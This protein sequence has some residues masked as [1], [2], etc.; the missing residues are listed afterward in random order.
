[1]N[2]TLVLLLLLAPWYSAGAEDA[3]QSLDSPLGTG[4]GLTFSTSSTKTALSLGL[5]Q[6]LVLPQRTEDGKSWRKVHTG[7]RWEGALE[8]AVQESTSAAL[9][10]FASGDVFAP[11]LRLKLGLAY[12]SA[13][14]RDDTE[15]VEAC[16]TF[17]NDLEKLRNTEREKR[18]MAEV[19]RLAQRFEI[20]GPT[21]EKCAEALGEVAGRI[22]RA[23]LRASVQRELDVLLD[24]H[25]DPMKDVSAATA[26]ALEKVGKD[27]SEPG[28]P[29]KKEKK[30]SSPCGAEPDLEP[31][32]E[33]DLY[34][35]TLEP[36]A[37][38]QLHD[39]VITLSGL[40]ATHSIAYRDALAD[41]SFDLATAQTWTRATFGAALDATYLF[42]GWLQSGIRVGYEQ[43]VTAKPVEICT[44]TAQGP[45]S[46]RSCTSA[47]LGRPDPSNVLAGVA[48]IQLSPMTADFLGNLA[49]GAQLLAR[50]ETVATQSA[51]WFASGTWGGSVTAPL[52]FSGSGDPWGLKAGLAPQV[53]FAAGSEAKPAFGVLLFVGTT[54]DAQPTALR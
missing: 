54:V 1:M 3:T 2:R 13:L 46:T 47:A 50:I 48:A 38:A 15:Y 32:A 51:P 14:A 8:G 5:S 40:A 30:F 9:L 11:G 36:Y 7:L 22:P 20:Q 45:L 28:A 34:A 49:F 19:G 18:C 37:K 41:G 4:T 10:D 52:F 16:D 42:S 24:T 43:K 33:E 23:M 29:K 26:K 25:L 21:A 27:L 12:S 39:V 44:T 35:K 53:T 31:G 6:Q 17:M